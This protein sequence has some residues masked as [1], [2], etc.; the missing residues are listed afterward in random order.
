[1]ALYF[2]PET[3]ENQAVRQCL[4]YFLPVFCYSSPENQRR[5]LNVSKR[6]RRIA[7]ELGNPTRCGLMR[8]S[9]QIAMSCFFSLLSSGTATV[10]SSRQGRWG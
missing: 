9:S 7:S 1:M 3:A 6:D 4:T 5:L 2:S 8:R 10:I